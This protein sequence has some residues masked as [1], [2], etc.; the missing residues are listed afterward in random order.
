MGQIR[1]WTIITISSF[2]FYLALT[3]GS[4]HIGVWSLEEIILGLAI[5]FVAALISQNVLHSHYSVKMFHIGRWLSFLR[6]GIYWLKLLTIANIDVAIRIFTG[7]IS[8]KI[9]VIPANQKTDFG[10]FMLANSITLTPGTLTLNLEGE[11]LRI[12]CIDKGKTNPDEYEKI[13]KH[14]RRILES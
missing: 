10:K 6:Y 12:H 8:P 4:G 11:N 9:I 14:I 13:S 2:L 5:S 1:S 3:P 7:N